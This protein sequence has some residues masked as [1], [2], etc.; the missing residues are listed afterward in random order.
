MFDVCCCFRVVLFYLFMFDKKMYCFVY[1]Q[2]EKKKNSFLVFGV[3][4]VFFLV[5]IF[6][7]IKKKSRFLSMGFYF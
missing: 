3:L 6:F 4:H 2:F 1:F 7:F 5:S